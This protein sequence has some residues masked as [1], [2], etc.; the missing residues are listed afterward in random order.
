MR[1]F[2]GLQ[3]AVDFWP[4]TLSFQLNAAVRQVLDP[5]GHVIT[6]RDFLNRKPESHTLNAALVDDALGSHSSKQ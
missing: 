4:V 6:M 3:E 1:V 2:D 5:T